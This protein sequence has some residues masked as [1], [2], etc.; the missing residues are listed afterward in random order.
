M[1]RRNQNTGWLFEELADSASLRRGA[2]R[3]ILRGNPGIQEDAS[4]HALFARLSASKFRS[5]FCL[6]EACLFEIRESGLDKIRKESQS[7][8]LTRLAPAR[9]DN[10][11]RQ[12]PMRGHPCFIAQ[13]ATGCCCRKCLYKWHGIPQGRALSENEL[14]YIDRVLFS[15]IISEIRRLAQS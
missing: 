15:W 8:T 5:R 2:A 12:T 14:S 1:S 11:G 6:D 3:D 4:L 13:H 7:L 10:D 9:P